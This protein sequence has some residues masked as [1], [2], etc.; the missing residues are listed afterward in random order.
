[1]TPIPVVMVQL[2]RALLLV[3]HVHVLL[4]ILIMTATQESTTA[5]IL[6]ALMVVL[7]SMAY[8]EHPVI[9]CQDILGF[10]V[11]LISTNVCPVL[12]SMEVAV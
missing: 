6:H 8:Q 2:V 5:T 7:A 1:M 3:M 11:R 12:V 4:D 9:A 10:T